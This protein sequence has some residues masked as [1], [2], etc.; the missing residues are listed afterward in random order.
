VASIRHDRVQAQIKE[1]ASNIILF[2]LKDPRVGFVTITRVD[3]SS[4]MRVAKIYYSVLGSDVDTKLTARAIGHARGHVQREIAKR[5]RLRFAPIITFELD[6]SPRK[7]I[8]L[9]NLIDEAVAEDQERRK[10]RED[11]PEPHEDAEE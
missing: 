5:V 10:N 1:I 8:E 2:Q 11:L 4:D 6:E 3:L 7:G 9:A